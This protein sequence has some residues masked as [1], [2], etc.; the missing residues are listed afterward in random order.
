MNAPGVYSKQRFNNYKCCHRK[1]NLKTSVP[2]ESFHEH[3]NKGNFGMND[4]QFTFID[5]GWKHGK[6][7]EKK[8]RFSNINLIVLFQMNVKWV[9]TVFYIYFIYIRYKY[10]IQVTGF[11]KS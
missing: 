10:A 1:Y 6:P 7:Q 9:Y 11:R 2:Q 8:R 3:F 5:K 4:W